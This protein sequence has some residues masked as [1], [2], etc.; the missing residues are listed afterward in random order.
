M[1]DVVPSGARVIWLGSGWEVLDL[2]E[3]YIGET[4]SLSAS[5]AG[6]ISDVVELDYQAKYLRPFKPVHL[7]LKRSGREASLSWI[8]QSRIEGE[9]WT[10]LDVPL[11][12]ETELY[13]VQ[14]LSDGQVIFESEVSQSQIILSQ[15]DIDK[16][17][18]ISIEQGSRAFGWG[19][20]AIIDTASLV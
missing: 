13:R 14:L 20:A 11:G 9:N 7:R 1:M 2:P 10:G 16:T 18:I 8:R 17:D 12:E 19:A 5:A 6:R 3:S 4:I 15:T